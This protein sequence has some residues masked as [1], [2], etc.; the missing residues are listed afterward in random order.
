MGVIWMGLECQTHP[1][2]WPPSLPVPC[3]LWIRNGLRRRDKAVFG[4]L[5]GAS[6]EWW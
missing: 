4:P 2:N 3:A 5:T 1:A 6:G